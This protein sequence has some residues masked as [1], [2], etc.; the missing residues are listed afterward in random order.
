M[1]EQITLKEVLELVSFVNIKGKWFVDDVLGEVGGS[2]LGTVAGDVEGAVCGSIG[3]DV[4]GSVFGSVLGHV[5]GEVVGGVHGMN[6]K[7]SCLLE[8]HLDN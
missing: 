7:V 3:D 6:R 2:V 8:N 1:S 4:L 5:H